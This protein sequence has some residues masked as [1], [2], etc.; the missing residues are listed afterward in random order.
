MLKKL[1]FIVLFISVLIFSTA[2]QSLYL[3]DGIG[4]SGFGI[5]TSFTPDG[6]ISS[7]ISAAYSI[8]SIMDIGFKL[9]R[10]NDET[11][12]DD[13]LVWNLEFLYNLIVLKQSQY[14]PVNLQ[15]EGL[16]GY[17][18]I[19]SD[20]YDTN[21]IS[22]E[23]FGFQIGTTLSHEFFRK[24]LFSFLIGAKAHYRNYLYTL[25]DANAVPAENITRDESMAAGGIISLS[26]HPENFPIITIETQI[27][28]DISN[29]QLQI[30]PTVFLISPRF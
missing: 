23:G 30:I 13:S 16:F 7:G 9:N 17:S 21:S 1:F 6:Y 11:L 18:N 22:E 24:R 5:T 25:T 2:A 27:I 14:N 10:I 20:Y 3:E 19:S 29:T 8:G 28:Y 15:L 4:G 26:L 12:Y